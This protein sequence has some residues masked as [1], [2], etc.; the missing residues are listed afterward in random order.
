MPGDGDPLVGGRILTEAQEDDLGR[1]Q[2]LDDE[3]GEGAWHGTVC[4]CPFLVQTVSYGAISLEGF[5]YPG[6]R[7]GWES[8]HL[9]PVEG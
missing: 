5:A 4:A 6:Q 9:R 7:N 8:Q 1:M 3:L 2:A